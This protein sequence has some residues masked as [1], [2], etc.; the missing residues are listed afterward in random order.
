MN[1]ETF[2]KTVTRLARSNKVHLRSRPNDVTTF[3]GYSFD[4]YRYIAVACQY[5][6]LGNLI[7]VVDVWEG[8]ETGNFLPRNCSYIVPLRGDTAS[9]NIDR[10]WEVV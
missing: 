4:P 3:R 10:L 1:K 5:D 8:Q 6:E 7:D 2:V 9:S